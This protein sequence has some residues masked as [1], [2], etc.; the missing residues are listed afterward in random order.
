[1][2][3]LFHPKAIGESEIKNRFVHSATFECMADDSGAVTDK[4]I[5]RYSRLA[6]GGVGLIIP[7]YCFIMSNG[8]AMNYQI[9]IHN[10]SMIDGLKM[11]VDAVHNEGGKIALQLVHS[12][13]QT[14][15]DT[16]GQTQIAPSKGSM[17][18]IFMARPREMK[19]SQIQEII[20]AFGAAADRAKRAGADGVQIHAAHGYLVNQFLSPFFNKRSDSWGGS[21]ENKF[22]FIK[23]VILKIKDNISNNMMLLVK[24]N[25][26]DF[27]PK[28]GI[29][30]DLAKKYSVWLSELPIDGLEVSCG[31]LSY[32]MFNMVRGDVPTEEIITNFPWWRKILG[33]LMLKQ[34]E[35]KFNLEE[36]YNIEA[37]RLIKP[38]IGDMPLMVVGGMRKIK[39]MEQVIEEGHADF[40]S[41]SRPFIREPNIINKFIDGKAVEVSCVSCN[42]C[43]AGVAN[44][45]PVACYNKGFPK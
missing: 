18:T 31:T 45:L 30:L 7:G 42:K 26:Q 9:G 11:L 39:H 38:V 33:K 8:R 22:R 14:A 28:T 17:D 24:M 3:V 35:G 15:K 37:A 19:D 1:M 32:S 29:T 12:G 13:R 5:K 41:M 27:T 2:S 43:F 34:M 36:G 6:K 44:Y 4:L 25:T 16:I 21:D 20:N 40:I 10:D 23:E